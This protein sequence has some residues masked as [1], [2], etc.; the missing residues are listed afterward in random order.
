MVIATV[1]GV[2]PGVL[3]VTIREIVPPLA[4]KLTVVAVVRGKVGVKRTVTV[5]DAPAPTRLN[6]LPATILNGA[7]ADAAP[8]TVP[9]AVFCTVKVRSAKPPRITVPKLTMPVG[10]T[11][12]S[13]CAAALPTGLAQALSLPLVSTAV[14]ET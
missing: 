9:P 3:P 2:R 6:G 1:G 12:N 7:E 5:C 13:N 14:T 8:E 4:V 10:F 11:A